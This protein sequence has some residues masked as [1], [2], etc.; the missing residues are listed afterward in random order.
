MKKYHNYKDVIQEYK[1]RIY[2]N[3]YIYINNKY[4]YCYLMA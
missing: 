1:N 4:Y 2:I 3:I